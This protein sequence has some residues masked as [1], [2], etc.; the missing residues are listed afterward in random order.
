MPNPKN[1]DQGYTLYY[2]LQ[3]V[4]IKH[5]DVKPIVANP[6]AKLFETKLKQAGAEL[7]QLCSS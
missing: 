3:I 5:R 2:Q 7:C 6:K 1:P 4:K